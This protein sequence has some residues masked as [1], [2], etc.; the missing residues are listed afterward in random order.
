MPIATNV[1]FYPKFTKY[2]CKLKHKKLLTIVR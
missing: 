2:F 1:T